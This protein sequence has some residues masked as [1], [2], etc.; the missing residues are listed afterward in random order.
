LS[1]EPTIGKFH[2][3]DNEE[4]DQAIE[5][6]KHSIPHNEAIG[7]VLRNLYVRVQKL[8]AEAKKPNRGSP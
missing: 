7:R 3:V 8:E 4:A 5:S 6:M 1:D 2:E